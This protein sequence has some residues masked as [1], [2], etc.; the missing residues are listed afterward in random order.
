MRKAQL[1]KFSILFRVD[2]GAA[3]GMGHVSRCLTLAKYLSLCGHRCIF[4]VSDKIISE[5][6]KSQNFEVFRVNQ[7]QKEE[8]FI[9]KIIS[10]ESCKILIIDS[11]RRSLQNIISSIQNKI[12]IIVID[13]IRLAKV[14][15]LV[16]MPTVKENY[17]NFPK[18]VLIGLEYVLVSS[19]FTSHR[20]PRS[21]N[22]ILISIGSSDKYNITQK[23][24]SSFLQEESKYKL[25]I[26]V[27]KFYRQEH[28][29]RK[30]V[31]ND[32]RIVV[33]SK[34]VCFPP[35]CIYIYKMQLR[36]NNIPIFVLIMLKL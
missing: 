27:G 5:L 17:K 12:K 1:E 23:L 26:V 11:K 33:V 36:V 21:K 20:K 19:N 4:V 2:G 18:N 24:V 28:K 30:L 6:I 32:K 7:N 22:T 10:K 9:K 34:D 15:D 25:I 3:I 16:I 29:I 13:N 14:A 31:F 35:I 8:K